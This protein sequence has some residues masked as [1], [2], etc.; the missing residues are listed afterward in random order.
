MTL[1]GAFWIGYLAVVAG[2]ILYLFAGP[3]SALRVGVAIA[4]TMT[5]VAVVLVGSIVYDTLTEGIAHE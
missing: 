2:S 3:I 4:S 5:Y 1:R